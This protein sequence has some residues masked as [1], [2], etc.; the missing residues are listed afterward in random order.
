MKLLCDREVCTGCGA[1]LNVCPCNAISMVQ[2][3]DG[4]HFP[5]IDREKCLGCYACGNVCPQLK[6]GNEKNVAVP[7]VYAVASKEKEDST[8][9]T[10]G[11]FFWHLAQRVLRDGGYVV[12]AVMQESWSVEL[13]MSNDKNVVERMR[14]SKYVESMAG[15]TFQEVKQALRSDATVLFCGLPCQVAGLL[16]YLGDSPEK[17]ITVDI[18]C[19]GTPSTGLFQ[20]YVNEL[21]QDAPVDKVLFRYKQKKWTPLLESN[22]YIKRKSGLEEIRDYKDDP[23]LIA[24]NSNGAF[25]ESC[26]SCKYAKIPRVAD[27]TIGD[28]MGL[29]VSCD[30]DDVDDAWSGGVSQVLINSDKGRKAF[31]EIKA[32]L[33]YAER[34]LRECFYFN[35]NL[36]KPSTRPDSMINF[37][38]EYS[39]NG[40]KFVADKYLHPKGIV[41]FMGILRKAIRSACGDAFALKLIWNSY[42][43]GGLI[44]RADEAFR[45]LKNNGK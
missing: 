40:W 26:Y 42:Q 25:R 21:E 34:S 28:F 1:C 20:A 15:L 37:Y 27:I 32:S 6:E 35:H 4:F 19:H 13:Q 41:R 14:G 22:V 43:R 44:E 2:H 3:A 29:G 38:S 39:E 7:H 16:S 17:L 8:A 9:S 18:V 30:F 33:I 23:Y 36:W 5:S 45:K 31:E 11:G 24:F 12:G 10:S